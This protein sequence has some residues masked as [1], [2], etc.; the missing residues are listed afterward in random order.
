MTHTSTNSAA[1]ESVRSAAADT[2]RVSGLTHR[3]YRYPARFSPQ[4]ARACIEAFSQPGEVVLDPYMGGATTVVEAMVLGRRAIGSDINSLSVFVARTKCAR[5]TESDKRAIYRWAT[6]VVPSI[7]CQDGLGSSVKEERVPLNMGA[8]GTRW[9]RKTL[10]LCMS[11]I[12]ADLRTAAARQFATCVL[13]NAGQWALDGRRRIPN[14]NDLR[15]RIKVLTAD[16]LAGVADLE[17]TLASG[18]STWYEPVLRQNDAELIDTDTCLQVFGPV[19]LV[20]T[21]QPYPGIHMLYHRWQVDGRKET[22]APYWIAN[23]TDG[24]GAAYYNF[25]DRKAAAE[26]RYYKKARK[27]FAAVRRVMRPGAVLAQLVA[28]PEPDRHLRRYLNA[29]ESAGFKEMQR[30]TARRI[31][32]AVPGRRWHAS[33]K[34]ELS[35]SK[36]VV[37]LHT[38][39]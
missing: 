7:R 30:P 4:F 13:L 21:S 11:A 28:F 9:L 8:P 36:E 1:F 37:L 34:G 35:S 26:D 23:C 6:E 25:A 22:D 19:D 33:S 5:L 31:W 16:M 17:N 12:A 29:M 3:F 32:R 2:Q 14:A 24:S 38:A 15:N 39:A 10:C 20:V 27:A 18:Q